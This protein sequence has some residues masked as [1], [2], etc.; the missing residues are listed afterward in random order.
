MVPGVF[1]VGLI[2]STCTATPCGPPPRAPAW[3]APRGTATFGN[4]M[5][6]RTP[7]T[8]IY[9]SDNDSHIDMGY[10][11]MMFEMTATILSSLISIWDILSPWLG[12]TWRYYG[13]HGSLEILTNVSTNPWENPEG[14][15]RKT[16]SRRS[17][18]SGQLWGWEYANDERGRGG[19]RRGAAGA[20]EAAAAAGAYTPS[21]SAKLELF[22][23]PCDPT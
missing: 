12:A 17:T 16:A 4:G 22:Y 11:L 15:A 1:N 6:A 9:Q 21:H 23:P 3:R 5:P 2:G 8:V 19:A 20:H 7:T 10:G 18:G 13:G 14:G